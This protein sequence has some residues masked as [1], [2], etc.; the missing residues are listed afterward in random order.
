MRHAAL[1]VI[2][3][4]VLTGPPSF[5]QSH[6]TQTSDDKPGQVTIVGTVT[7]FDVGKSIEVNSNGVP[8][9]YDLNNSDIVY[10]ISPEVATGMTVKV[11]GGAVPPERGARGGKGERVLGIASEL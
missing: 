9:K 11:M 2:M 10:S 1:T 6:P 5:S 7:S 3:A 4:F 8:H